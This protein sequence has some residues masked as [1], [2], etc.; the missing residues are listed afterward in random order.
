MT[1][2]VWMGNGR[3]ELGSMDMRIMTGRAWHGQTKRRPLKQAD[4]QVSMILEQKDKC[5]SRN[6]SRAGAIK[7][8][9]VIH[10]QGFD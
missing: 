6:T 1:V 7:K 4:R 9:K 5:N 3:V 2:Q 8:I 10:E